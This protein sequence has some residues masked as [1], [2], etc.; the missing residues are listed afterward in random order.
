MKASQ[1]K[2]PSRRNTIGPRAT[3]GRLRS[4]GARRPGLLAAVAL[5][6][7][8]E[9]SADWAR[10]H[11]GV[12]ENLK[13]VG[14]LEEALADRA[15][16]LSWKLNRVTRERDAA[17]NGGQ[18]HETDA[19]RSL[20]RHE[21]RRLERQA[22]LT[23]L[24]SLDEPDERPVDGAVATAA[25]ATLMGEADEVAARS[26]GARVALGTVSLPGIPVPGL[27]PENDSWTTKRLRD[28]AESL[29]SGAGF[30][31]WEGLWHRAC[32]RVWRER[33]AAE[34]RIAEIKAAA[35][36]LRRERLQRTAGAVDEASREESTLER[37]LFRTLHELE[38]LQARRA[39]APPLSPT[40]QP[41]PD[42]P[43]PR[44]LSR[45]SASQAGVRSGLAA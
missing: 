25:L 24:E 19:P 23:V 10:H 31:S 18:P 32:A 9:Q 14:T 36:R 20:A 7:D 2:A 26:T 35:E 21:E 44:D 33:Q 27:F 8:V 38:H 17:A 6:P 4:E 43:A 28:E 1:R 45:T 34:D 15:A 22:V 12:I 16:L 29:A 3:P 37:S 40:A 39:A 13:P 11:A 30:R 5:G 42:F 41:L